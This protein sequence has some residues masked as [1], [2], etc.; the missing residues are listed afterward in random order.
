MYKCTECGTEY[1]IKPD[2]CDCGNDEFVITVEE[3]KEEPVIVQELV[4]VKQERAKEPEVNRPKLELPKTDPISITIFLICIIL[5][6][7]IA[8]LPIK[9]NEN[10]DKTKITETKTTSNIPSIDKFWNNAVPVT[11]KPVTPEPVAVKVVTPVKPTPT[12]SA[13]TLPRGEGVKKQ[14]TTM[15][16]PATNKKTTNTVA[17]Q[18]KKAE[19]AKKKAEEAKQ[20]EAQ[21]KAEENAKKLAEVKKHAEDLQQAMYD[22]QELANYKANLRN[23]IGR[24]IDFTK[25]LGDGDCAITFKIDSNGRL[26]SGAFAKQ[27]TNITLND[28]VY[29]AFMS[30]RNQAAPPKLYQNET[31]K[32]TVKFYNGNF[33]ISL[34]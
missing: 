9:T 5:S 29:K 25:V 24:K 17:E 14:T 4:K 22:K 19:E 6:F 10:T 20:L 26:V 3:K 30:S 18:A 7:V 1:E 21:R 34:N 15:K 33:E 8:F 31:L 27:S 23:N 13:T 32:L 11:E 12:R 16:T 28:A 2:Y